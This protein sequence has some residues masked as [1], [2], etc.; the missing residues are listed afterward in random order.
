MASEF[1][2]NKLQAMF[3]AFDADGNG[4]LEEGDFVALADRWARL[5]RV[6]PGSELAGRVEDVLLGWWGQLTAATGTARE[7]RIDLDGILSVVDRLPAMSE[8]VTATADTIF[9]A[10]DE[11][12]DGRIS[13]TEH[14]RLVDTWHGQGVS[15]AD[16][17]DRLDRDGDGYLGRAEFAV[18]WTQFWVSDD[19][20]EPGNLL[21]GPLP[22]TAG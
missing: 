17:F 22:G 10:V 20:R 6:E 21:C 5:P 12:G 11:N 3:D 1:Q 15:T 7:G 9:D 18:L 13:R 14:Q 8:Q 16:V 4:Y 2:R 19:P